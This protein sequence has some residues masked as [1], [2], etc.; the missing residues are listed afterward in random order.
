M[1]LY[2]NGE[3][4]DSSLEGEKTVWDVIVSLT[5]LFAEEDKIITGVTV[6]GQFYSS[7]NDALQE[8]PVEKIENLELEVADKQEVVETLV[9]KSREICVS[10]AE[11]LKTNSYAHVG[12][13]REIMEWVLE[14]LEIIQSLSPV[15]MVDNTLIRNTVRELLMYWES[16]QK[17]VEDIPQL[18]QVMQSLAQYFEL[19]EVKVK[20][21]V[22]IERQE[23]EDALNGLLETLPKIAENFQ[24]GQD[25]MAF[26]KIHQ[27]VS[28]LES[29]VL[30]L[31]Q[32]EKTLSSR[33]DEIESLAQG[34]NAL[35]ADIVSAFEKSDVVLLGDL[36]EYELPEK[37]E[38]Y[39]SVVWEL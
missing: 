24:L 37:I 5:R 9:Q 31:R 8:F 18:I 15:E 25:K 4:I 27:V 6:N 20:T 38:A 7:D 22:R 3:K 39:K 32:N 33:E 2:I 23:L 36:L 16:P 13:Y 1:Q 10:I 19:L 28:V 29:A 26:D 21:P 34:L 11:D 12:Q 17:V 35:L 14:V 30:Y